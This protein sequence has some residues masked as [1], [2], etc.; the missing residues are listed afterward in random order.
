LGKKTVS[1]PTSLAPVRPS[2]AG[3]RLRPGPRALL[4]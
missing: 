4:R 2:A 1:G 3:S